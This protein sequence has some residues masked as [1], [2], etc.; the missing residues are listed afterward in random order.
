MLQMHGIT[1]QWTLTEGCDNMPYWVFIPEEEYRDKMQCKVFKQT[2]KP[3]KQAK[4]IQ[5]YPYSFSFRTRREVI[6]L[7]N[8][9]GIA[10]SMRP[11]SYKTYDYPSSLKQ[12]GSTEKPEGYK[13]TIH[14][15]ESHQQGFKI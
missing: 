8:I 9:V 5:Y 10:N 12:P 14:K 1:Y 3:D 2:S 13:H 7:F 4:K 11:K 15:S 6:Q